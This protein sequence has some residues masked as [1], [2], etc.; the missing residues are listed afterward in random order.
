MNFR[1]SMHIKRVG[2]AKASEQKVKETGQQDISDTDETL[3]RK[4]ST[5]SNR[6]YIHPTL[7]GFSILGGHQ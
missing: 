1:I 2:I 6:T 4:K 5:A 3:R 7:S